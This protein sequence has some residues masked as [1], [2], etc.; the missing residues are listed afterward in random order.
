MFSHLYL[1]SYATYQVP[2]I[3]C[4]DEGLFYLVWEVIFLSKL[5]QHEETARTQDS[6]EIN[7]HCTS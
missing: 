2:I 7:V 3:S 1:D 6:E 4:C 5:F